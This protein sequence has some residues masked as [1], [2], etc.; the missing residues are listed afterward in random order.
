MD[1][2]ASA[3]APPSYPISQLP[4]WVV[5]PAKAVPMSATRTTFFIALSLTASLAAAPP[6][7]EP[8]SSEVDFSRQL[9]PMLTQAG[10]NSGACHG[11]AAG[12]GYLK[13][14]L[15][16]S[17]PL[18]DFDTILHAPAGRLIDLEVAELS[19]LLQKTYRLP[20]TWRR[21]PN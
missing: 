6:E 11:A 18:E 10:C 5:A 19:L 20:R 16:G 15:Y 2:L 3:V 12:R 4:N 1:G 14:S 8:T 13:L 21:N 7:T 9:I 17:R